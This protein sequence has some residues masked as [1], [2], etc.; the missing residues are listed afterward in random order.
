MGTEKDIQGRHPADAEEIKQR[1]KEY[2]EKLCKKDP[3]ELDDYDGVVS[4]PEPDILKS[5]ARWA[6]GSAAINKASGCNGIPVELCKTMKDDTINVLH[7]I[8]QKSG[9]PS[10]GHRTEKVNPHPNFQEEYY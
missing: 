7:L 10:S 4:H 9:R 8:R 6:L 1:W 3:N 5:E 2:T